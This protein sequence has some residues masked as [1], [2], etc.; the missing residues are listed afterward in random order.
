[1][2]SFTKRRIYIDL[3][4]QSWSV[5]P[6]L[7]QQIVELVVAKGDIG[8]CPDLLAL[9]ALPLRRPR[10][11][12][13]KSHHITDWELSDWQDEHARLKQGLPTR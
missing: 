1:M 4:G 9:G 8:Q 2:S 12:R 7:W 10:G 6:S 13:A 11:K 5:P 3:K